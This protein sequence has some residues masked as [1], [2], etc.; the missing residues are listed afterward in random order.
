MNWF[1][2]NTRTEK[3][4]ALEEM[5]A[6][7]QVSNLAIQQQIKMIGLN[8]DD[9]NRIVRL[10]PAVEEN[11]NSIVN[12]FY[13]AI[14]EQQHLVTI[15]EKHSSIDRLK[16]T[17]QKHILEMFNGKVDDEFVQKRKMISHMHVKIGL[18]PNFYLCAFQNLQIA[19]IALCHEEIEEKETCIQTIKSITT[20][21][22]LEQQI[23]LTA[24]EEAFEEQ[25]QLLYQE[26]KLIQDEISHTS[27]LLASLSE[28]TAQFVCQIS[29]QTADVVSFANK[30]SELAEMVSKDAI[31]SQTKLEQ[32][33]AMLNDIQKNTSLIQQRMK[34]LEDT[35]K[36]ITQI[37][38]IVTSIAEQTN[39][40]ALNASI[41]SARAGEHGKGF[42]VVAQ[43]VRK[44]AEETKK[45]IAN[46]STF[47]KD[48]QKQIKSVAEIGD[49]VAGL[50][51][52]TT[53]NMNNI[54]TFFTN[55]LSVT[56]ENK[57]QSILT[58]K[59]L[60]KISSIIAELTNRID[61]IAASS[62][63]LYTLSE[64]V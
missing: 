23:V 58:K 24:Y 54:T 56:T 50:T 8:L 52:D 61:K 31:E 44:L 37:V 7:M 64:K 53:V 26:K 21:I 30:S 5:N 36:Q 42:A 22:N 57:Q 43:E 1:R 3:V 62:D 45:S 2:R 19:L 12:E 38:A 48:I 20:L 15:I 28:E 29:G 14:G 40:L 47:I 9:L 51:K 63:E 49:E 6:S 17:L 41:E 18:E 11:L 34:T 27:S 10:Q 60:D 55:V 39:L 33:Q 59:E 35:S 25:R 4:V 32:E 16:N 13:R 46:I